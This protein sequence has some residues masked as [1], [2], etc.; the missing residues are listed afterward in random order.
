MPLWETWEIEKPTGIQIGGSVTIDGLTGKRMPK[1][2]F[3][4]IGRRKRRQMARELA[5]RGWQVI[6][7]QE[8]R[9]GR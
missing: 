8:A 6:S 7:E 5:K 2:D 4:A 1:K 3:K 9:A